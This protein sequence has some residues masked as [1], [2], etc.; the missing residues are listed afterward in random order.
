MRPIVRG[1]AP[2]DSENQEITYPQYD[3]ARGE[4]IDRLGEY[5]SYCEM[6]VDADLAVEHVRPK[7]PASGLQA[8]RVGDWHNFLL[9]CR[10]CNSTKGKKEG[11]IGD[12]YWPDRD[13]TFRALTYS[14]GGVIAAAPEVDKAK[15]D[16]TIKLTGLDK[17]PL[18]NP[19]ASDRRW[20]NRREAWDLA[21]LSKKDLKQCDTPL[22]R[23]QVLRTAQAYWSVWMTV[24]KDDPN[25]LQGLIEQ[26]P[27]TC[28]DCFDPKS[29]FKPIPRP[30]GQC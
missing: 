16:N 30:G 8:D 6:H 5:C 23:R 18:N 19:A 28:M 22:M 13:N 15:A 3:K 2:R 10:N 25:M 24:F 14:E 7:H 27:G 20:N 21:E 1:K 12:C 4:L 11:A 26:F 29:D 9:A 17:N